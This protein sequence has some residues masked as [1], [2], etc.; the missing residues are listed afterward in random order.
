MRRLKALSKACSA[1]APERYPLPVRQQQLALDAQELG[2]VP[3]LVPGLASRQR[4][5]DDG[6]PLRIPRR[7][8][9][10]QAAISPRRKQEARQI[11]RIA[12]QL[13]APCASTG[14]P[15]AT[16]R[17][18]ITTPLKARAHMFHSRIG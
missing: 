17:L 11:S 7:P 14:N 13:R 5:I 10:E 4:F 6:E 8:H 16:P 3:L 15:V 12:R 9:R 1:A 18:A 2:L